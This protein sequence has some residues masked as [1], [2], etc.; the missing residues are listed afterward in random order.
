MTP[1]AKGGCPALDPAQCQQQHM[2][3]Q[4]PLFNIKEYSVHDIRPLRMRVVLRWTLCLHVF[5]GA[6][7]PVC[8]VVDAQHLLCIWGEP[9]GNMLPIPIMGAHFANVYPV[10]Q[11][12]AKRGPRV[13]C[14]INRRQTARVMISAS[15]QWQP[16]CCCVTMEDTC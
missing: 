1:Y 11:L 5:A 16:C 7:V 14:N 8:A 15:K 13:L 3:S 10:K 9:E 2:R 12:Q 4:P 6:A